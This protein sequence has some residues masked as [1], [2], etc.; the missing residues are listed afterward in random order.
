MKE[1]VWHV[2]GI[3]DHKSLV[4]VIDE[5]NKI[6]DFGFYESEIIREGHRWAYMD[7]LISIT[8]K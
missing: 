3:P 5:E 2:D 1:K 6:F 4:I 7:D 8:T